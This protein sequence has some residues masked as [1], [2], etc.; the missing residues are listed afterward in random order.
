MMNDIYLEYILK[1]KK[2]GGQK[3]IIAVI[4]F[5]AIIVS[6]ALL[7]LIFATATALSGTQFGS[8]SFSIG[9]VL[10]SMQNI[11]YEYIL[12]NSEIDIDKIMSKKARKRIASFDFKE[13]NICANINDN[14]H[15][16]DYK[17][18]T[19]SKT[20][21]VT[22]DKSRGNVYFVDYSQDSENYRVLFQPTSKMIESIK[23][24]NPR[25]VFVME[26]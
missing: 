15:N 23:R 6:L 2:T 26:D 1:K 9:L 17:N 21:D 24:F 16:H 22:G 8:F 25:N 3:A 4:I 12:T 7:L 11:E 14:E 19:V 10:M 13:I 20:F 5:A 18:V